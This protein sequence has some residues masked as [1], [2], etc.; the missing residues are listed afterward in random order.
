MNRIPGELPGAGR[1]AALGTVVPVHGDTG[2]G[3]SGDVDVLVRP[4]G[5]RS[6]SGAGG[7]GIVA[8]LTFLGAVTRVSVLLSGDVTVK[9]DVP[10][11]RRRGSSLASG[12]SVNVRRDR[13][14]SGPGHG[15]ADHG[16]ARQDRRLLA[17]AS[18]RARRLPRAACPP[19]ASRTPCGTTWPAGPC[20]RP[21]AGQPGRCW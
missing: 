20:G 10:Q 19:T 15:A 12:T 11:R 2:A 4:E 5:L 7:N 17:R 13:R 9:V 1:V 21:G 16:D 18:R 14:R 6:R 3:L 8:D